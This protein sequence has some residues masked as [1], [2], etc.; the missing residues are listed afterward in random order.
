MDRKSGQE[1]N[2]IYY[3]YILAFLFLFGAVFEGRV[4]HNHSR[5]Y[6]RY[7]S[8][9]VEILNF[10]DRLLNIKEWMFT[11]SGWEGK[12]FS[13]NEALEHADEHYS[14]VKEYSLCF[15]GSAAVFIVVVLVL[16][17]GGRVFYR[18]SGLTIITIAMAC[19]VMGVIVPMLEISAYSTDFTIPLNISLPWIGNIDIP[20]KV[21]EGRIYFYY[22]CKSVID[23]VSVLFEGRNHAVAASI[24]AF[25][26]FVPFV[27][28]ALSILLLSMRSFRENVHVKK[29][30]DK[31]GKWSMADVFIAATFLS[32]LSFSNMNAGIETEASTLAGLYF[33]LAYCVL[34]LTSSQF[35]ER[36]LKH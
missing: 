32:Y 25:S 16:Y 18:V 28:L 5:E 8:E 1:K 9:Y 13:S 12:A 31:I 29:I 21:F 17:R 4:I 30:V 14:V 23:L 19:L 34:S 3:F 15:A 20:D 10:R 6:V 36:A 2:P 7:K 22:Q 33:F 24:I 11:G 35:V 26:V 27:K